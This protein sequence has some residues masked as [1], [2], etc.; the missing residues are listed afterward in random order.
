M[1]YSTE[2]CH[3]RHCDRL[4]KELENIIKQKCEMQE[5][6]EQ[7]LSC[8]PDGTEQTI[9]CVPEGSEQTDCQNGKYTFTLTEFKEL[10]HSAQHGN[11]Q[12]MD[13]LCTAFKPLIYWENLFFY[14]QGLGKSP[15]SSAKNP[16]LFSFRLSRVRDSAYAYALLLPYFTSIL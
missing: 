3:T 5:Y 4:R 9:C 6:T 16:D 14:C 10:V 12:S 7:E 13:A 2:F 8:L 1:Q 15:F 11:S